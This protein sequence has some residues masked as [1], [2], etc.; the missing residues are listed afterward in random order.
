[1][2]TTTTDEHAD[3]DENVGAV[4]LTAFPLTALSE[5]PASYV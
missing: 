3:N 5:S 4:M 1:M 2:S